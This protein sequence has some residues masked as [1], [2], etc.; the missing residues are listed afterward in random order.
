MSI[1]AGAVAGAIGGGLAVTVLA[2]LSAANNFIGSFFFGNGMIVGERKAYQEDWPKIKARLDKGESFITILEEYT[3]ENTTA[4]MQTAKMVLDTVTPIWF[5]MVSEYLKSIPQELLTMVTNPSRQTS[6]PSVVKSAAN[7]TINASTWGLIPEA[8]AEE[9]TTNTRIPDRP[10]Y[11][12]SL[13]IGQLQTRYL[14]ET[15]ATFKLTIYREIQLRLQENPK[16]LNPD[17]IVK[18]T[19]QEAINETA[20]GISRQI[21]NMY[22]QVQ[23]VLTQLNKINK[24]REPARYNQIKKIL[25]TT[26]KSYNQFVQLNRKPNLAIN[27]DKSIL[28]KKIV[29]K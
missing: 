21:A 14:R 18:K 10:S 24:L 1:A 20:T 29:P 2:P 27:T 15:D 3:T 6:D 5:G 26:V 11:F 8:F 28:Q 22:L 12:D 19:S 23:H 13:S 25:F 16:I 9:Q 4:V 7:A 17:P